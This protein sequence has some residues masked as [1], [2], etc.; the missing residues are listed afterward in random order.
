[1]PGDVDP[2]TALGI[3]RLLADHLASAGRGRYSQNYRT[4]IALRSADD[5]SDGDDAVPDRVLD[6]LGRG[7]DPEHFHDA[8]P[9]KFRGP[10]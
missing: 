5:P 9:M 1:M 10:R 7:P 4:R 3:R 2:A 6:Q 8:S